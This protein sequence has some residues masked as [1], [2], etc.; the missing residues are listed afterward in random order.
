MYSFQCMFKSTAAASSD[1]CTV[2]R[3][4][5]LLRQSAGA[6]LWPSTLFIVLSSDFSI[7]DCLWVHPRRKGEPGLL[8]S[9]RAGTSGARGGLLACLSR[10]EFGTGWGL[11]SSRG[12]TAIGSGDGEITKSPHKTALG[13]HFKLCWA[14]QGFCF[15]WQGARRPRSH[16]GLHFHDPKLHFPLLLCKILPSN[17]RLCFPSCLTQWASKK[18]GRCRRKTLVLVFGATL[19]AFSEALL[20]T[21]SPTS[22]GTE[23]SG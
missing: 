8:S 5:F 20:K 9:Q 4:S 13:P 15:F 17:E 7:S 3:L 22:H 14:A 1:F 18:Q 23:T 10:K 16:V 11:P 6:A 19:I 12:V 2:P 21:H